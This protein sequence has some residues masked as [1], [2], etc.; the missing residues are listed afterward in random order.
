[1]KLA[2]QREAVHLAAGAERERGRS[3]GL[4]QL[5]GVLPDVDVLPAERHVVQV[6]GVAVLAAEGRIAVRLAGEGADDAERRAV[7]LGEDRVDLRVRRDRRVDDRFHV[8]LGLL[9]L[10][11]VG[12]GAVRRA[13]DLDVTG[14]DLVLQ[15]RLV[16][17]L[18]QERLGVRVA[19]VA[20]DQDVVALRDLLD[21]RVRLG[22]ADEDV[23]EGDVQGARVLDQAVVR[24]DRDAR[25]LRLRDRR[26]DRLG[27]LR[28]DDQDLGALRDH[29]VDVGR[30]LLVAQVG[31][32]I[33]VLA[34]G[35]LDRLLDVRLVMRRPARLLEVVPRHADGAADSARA[36]R[37]RRCRGSRRHLPTGCSHRCCRRPR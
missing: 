1:M 22:L 28:E 11:G 10:P 27:V 9:G 34:A 4:A 15:A 16:P 25:R 35:A 37:V 31:V 33:D 6:G 23:V 19:R 36:E 24:D 14:G 17:A 29:G 12:V 13:D 18:R 32:G 26:Q 21:D 3:G 2:G 8:R 20:L 30:L 5:V 7:V